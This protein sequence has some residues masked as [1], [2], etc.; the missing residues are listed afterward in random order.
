MSYGLRIKFQK[1]DHVL[2][3]YKIYSNGEKMVRLVIDTQEM[4][5]KIVDPVTGYALEVGGGVT[6]LEVLQRK[7]KKALKNFLGIKFEKESRNV[8][9]K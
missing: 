6:N 2:I 8:Q 9:P 4:V 5:Y 3:S 1:H 7:A